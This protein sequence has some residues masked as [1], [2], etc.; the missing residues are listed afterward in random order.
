MTDIEKVKKILTE[1]GFRC[2]SDACDEDGHV[3]RYIFEKNQR[4]I[5]F[6]TDDSV[7]WQEDAIV[8]VEAK[9]ENLI[10]LLNF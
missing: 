4:Q 7:V 9:E 2:Q 6:Y 10:P 1:E 5:I 8:G 3:Q